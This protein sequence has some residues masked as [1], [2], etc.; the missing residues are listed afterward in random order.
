VSRGIV[1]G[2]ILAAGAVLVAL[3]T[4]AAAEPCSDVPGMPGLRCRV[5]ELG[6]QRLLDDPRLAKAVSK[7]RRVFGRARSACLA[8]RNP[9]AKRQL[10]KMRKP[11]AKVARMLERAAEGAALPGVQSEELR[12]LVRLVD[13]QRRATV[14]RLD[15]L[16]C[17][18][19]LEVIEPRPQTVA[20]S[21]FFLSFTLAAAVDARAV[22]V[23]MVRNDAPGAA[24]PVAL[25]QI[26][27]GHGWAT[28]TCPAPGTY[29]LQIR[30]RDADLIDTADVTVHCGAEGRVLGGDVETLIDHD[31]GPDTLALRPVRPLAGGATYAL[32]VTDGVRG[33][34]RRHAAPSAAFR[35]AAGMPPGRPGIEAHWE[36]DLGDPRNPFPDDRLR[37]EDGTI[38]IPPGFSARA[39][40]PDARLDGVRAFLTRLDAD[41]ETHTGFSSSTSVVIAFDDEIMLETATPEHVRLIEVRQPEAI[42]GDPAALVAAL[43]RERGIPPGEVA[44]ATTFTTEALPAELA[45]VRAQLMARAQTAPPVADFLT[46]PNPGDQ[47]IFGVFAPGDPEFA[48]FFGGEPPA[49]AALVAR[50]LFAS[51]DYRDSA[52][53]AF[54]ARFLDGSE[55]PPHVPIDFLVVVPGG[56]M[57]DG[58][59]PTVILQHGFS[60][61]TNFVTDHAAEFTA[62][63]L[64]VIGIP[65]PYHGSRGNIFE[66]LVFENFNAFGNNFR[67]ASVDLLQLVRLLETGL[68]VDGDSAVD[69]NPVGLGYLGVSLGGVIGATFASIEPAVTAAVLNVPGGRLAQFAGSVSSLATPFLVSFADEAGIPAQTCG[70][71]ADAASCTS[72]DDCAPDVACVFGDD[73]T[74]ML[75][76]ALPN[77]QWQLDPGDGINYVR[78][79]RTEPLAG[80][81]RAVL[82]QEGVGDAVVANPLTEALVR[83]LGLPADRPDQ[84]PRGVAGLWHVDPNEDVPEEERIEPHGIFSALP[85]VRH[86]AVTFLQSGGTMLVEPVVPVEEPPTVP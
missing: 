51:P 23:A 37:H 61:D 63:G 16:P 55:I 66:F 64:A 3:V 38:R 42:A 62:A 31:V 6:E 17:P 4:V 82:V 76:A 67:Q 19:L 34:R 18:D 84:N 56:E 54:P 77:F 46:D 25:D 52:T 65:A 15:T 22:G 60:G 2:A 71:R 53:G 79:L 44:L 14:A 35:D 10:R 32:V 13:A 83:G 8:G 12:Q 26:S 85:G 68:D 39:L 20:G 1:P 59:Y 78:H 9:K 58:G 70:G 69:L 24:V 7:T 74:A 40:S 81:P 5:A 30:A 21:D 57:P 43:E 49:S 33:R 50:G 36:P 29:R 48:G 72:D 86:Q 75:A 27:R 41:S 11:L 73:F 28:V 45:A 47:R 80:P